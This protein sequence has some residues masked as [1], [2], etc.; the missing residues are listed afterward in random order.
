MK[1]FI[2]LCLLIP[3]FAQAD[4]QGKVVGILDGDTVTV[5]D[6]DQ[7]QHRVRLSGIDAPEKRQAFGQRSKESLS[8]CAFDKQAVIEGSKFDRYKRLVGKVVVNGQD[9][10][11]SQVKLGLA[12][13]YKKYQ[14]EQLVQD[15]QVYATEEDTA[16]LK[17]LGL[18]SEPSPTPPWEFRHPVK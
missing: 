18:W 10:N 4:I 6:S 8:D 11:L 3:A 1:N 14:K 16:R 9:C 15:R 2:Y 5:L 7:V 12:W 13:H 17:K